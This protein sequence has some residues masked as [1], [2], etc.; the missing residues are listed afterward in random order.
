MGASMAVRGLTFPLLHKDVF[1][2]CLLVLAVYAA[3]WLGLLGL[4]ARW[5]QAAVHWL[6]GDLQ[7]PQGGA[8]WRGALTAIARG[9]AYV[10]TWAAAILAASLL[11]L[12]LCGP[13]LS[14]LADRVEA[15]A[16]G[17][18]GPLPAWT[19]L[20]A[21]MG[22]GAV[23]SAVLALLLAIGSALIWLVGAAVGALIPP[24]GG[25]WTLLAGGAWQALGAAS[26]TASFALENQRTSLA[27][28]LATLQRH[29]AIWLGFGA[30][31]LPL[32]WLPLGVPFAVT[33]ATL[34]VLRLHAAGELRLPARDGLP[35]PIF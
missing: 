29:R 20:V 13:L 16:A 25:L 7:D 5:D 6:T 22:R 18:T 27:E 28:Q 33:G 3:I 11:A 4:A 31:A 8:W 12:P 30:L 19:T 26:M 17:Q 32:C 15:R 9:A 21:E 23:R 1:L 34:L 14:L 10:L 24:L 35:R 2:M